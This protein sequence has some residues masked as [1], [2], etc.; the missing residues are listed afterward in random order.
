MFNFSAEQEQTMQSIAS[1]LND[2]LDNPAGEDDFLPGMVDLYGRGLVLLGLSLA[3]PTRTNP[4]LFSDHAKGMIACAYNHYVND[5]DHRRYV[6]SKTGVKDNKP[7]IYSGIEARENYLGKISVADDIS[8]EDLI[9]LMGSSTGNPRFIRSAL[10]RVNSQ[11]GFPG[12]IFNLISSSQKQPW[13]LLTS[14]M[15]NESSLSLIKSLILKRD[16]SAGAKKIV[17]Y[18]NSVFDKMPTGDSVNL[19]QFMME[20]IN[21]PGESFEGRI[22]PFVLFLHAIK[23]IPKIDDRQLKSEFIGSIVTYAGGLSATKDQ[24]KDSMAY[25]ADIFDVMVGVLSE[26]AEKVRGDWILPKDFYAIAA[27]LSV[28]K[29]DDFKFEVDVSDPPLKIIFGVLNGRDSHIEN[30][31]KELSINNPIEINDA[32]ESTKKT[33]HLS[34]VEHFFDL[35]QLRLK[36]NKRF[37]GLMLSDQLGL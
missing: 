33:W 20:H 4:N 22:G 31:I 8:N 24:F 2:Y 1:S 32:L 16:G 25:R 17:A 18:R 30:A 28:F 3:L 29:N 34:V 15:D 7:I 12:L 5:L 6:D 10:N 26:I 13:D 21:N 23:T 35:D 11:P 27:C 37:N 36:G 14:V 19:I 9:E